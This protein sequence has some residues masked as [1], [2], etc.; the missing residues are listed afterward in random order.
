MREW[1]GAAAILLGVG[2]PSVA[3][4]GT[5]SDVAGPTLPVLVHMPPPRTPGPQAPWPPSGLLIARLTVDVADD[6]TVLAVE[7]PH[8]L[9]P[10]FVGPA[11]D[12]ARSAHFRPARDPSGVVVPARVQLELRFD[13]SA[14][15]PVA[16][17]G[18]ARAAGSSATLAGV[19][20]EATPTTGLPVLATT[21]PDGQFAFVGLSDGTW[22]LRGTGPG[23]QSVERTLE[24][25][26]GVVVEVELRMVRDAALAGDAVGAELVVRRPQDEAS[27]TERP[28]DSDLARVLPGTNGD[29]VKVVQSLPGVAR[30]PLGTG[31]LIIRGT[32]PE[33]SAGFVDGMPLPMVFHFGGLSTVIYGRTVAEVGYV[34]GNAGVRYGRFLGGLVDIRTRDTRPEHTERV[35]HVDLFQAGAF[36][37]TPVGQQSA[38][39]I[40]AR[41]S[42][43]DTV[44]QGALDARGV[45]VRA[46]VFA[47]VQARWLRVFD[48]G[49]RA[50][51]LMLYSHDTFE[52]LGVEGGEESAAVDLDLSF[53]RLRGRVIQQ[54]GDFE[55]ELTASI[56][57]DRESLASF[58]WDEAREEVASVAVRD[59]WLRAVTRGRPGLRLGFDL[60][61][62]REVFLYDME[63]FGPFEG[64]ATPFLAPA[65]YGEL[66]VQH[67]G[68][69]VTP[70][71]RG[72]LVVYPYDAVAGSLDPRLHTRLAF[73]ETHALTVATGTY[74]RLPA[75][76]QMLSSSDGNPTLLAERAWQNSVGFEFLPYSG[77]RVEVTGFANVHD[78]RIVGREDRFQ[79]ATGPLLQVGPV[80]DG[81]YDNTGTGTIFGGELLARVDRDRFTGWVAATVSR[82]RRV[83]APGEDPTLFAYDQP[84]VLTALGTTALPRNWRLGGRARLTSGNPYTPVANRFQDMESRQFVPV[85]G[86][87]TTERLAPF[88]ALDL[89]VDKTY[90]FET[91]RLTASLDVQNISLRP[92]PE[93]PAWN[94]TYTEFSPITG[95]PPIPVFGLEGAW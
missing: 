94:S 13:R 42:Y 81:P 34:P 40:S 78:R 61:S 12:A 19:Q 72:D 49:T 84:I 35:V 92:N 70:G 38:V 89:R 22:T 43:I 4:E 29:V 54:V 76:R 52:Y 58:S 53:W 45:P 73:D 3:S 11:I 32:A 15:P 65:L 74:S 47:D 68:L 77:L 37:D 33:D 21:G 66:A 86:T 55:H 51:V 7:A 59:E 24:V 36:V 17:E 57:V 39:T 93:L 18:R 30:A 50:E 56:G 71:L 79:F 41:R 44:L 64:G 48:D 63:D 14:P 80:D 85:Y 2:S 95:L 87:E 27:V 8:E 1:V 75:A 9:P 20:I 67:R 16:I 31:N 82:S 46:P 69:T 5:S 90:T 23:L 62:G 26:G 60:W 25:R 6:G 88:F 10:A 28:L 83:D 91:W